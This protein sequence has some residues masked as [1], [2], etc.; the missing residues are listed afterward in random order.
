MHLVLG[1]VKDGHRG[2]L[3]LEVRVVLRV[4][5]LLLKVDVA[6]ELLQIFRELLELIVKVFGQLFV[7][8]L[9][10]AAVND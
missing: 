10:C 5:V 3:V 8:D 1:W 9:L 2:H 4:R 6:V 7:S